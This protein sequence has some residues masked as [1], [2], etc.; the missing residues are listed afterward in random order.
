[1]TSVMTV[2]NFT[3]IGWQSLTPKCHTQLHVF[4]TDESE[5]AYHWEMEFIRP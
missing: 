3:V 4:L 5:V 2:M 1:M